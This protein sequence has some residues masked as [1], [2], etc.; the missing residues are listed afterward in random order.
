MQSLV[1]AEGCK[2]AGQVVQSA[3]TDY[4]GVSRYALQPTG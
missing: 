4:T 2:T 3:S 1:S